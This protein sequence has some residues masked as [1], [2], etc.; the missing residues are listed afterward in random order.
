MTQ[1]P[2]HQVPH[3]TDRE[4]QKKDGNG[5]EEAGHDSFIAMARTPAAISMSEAITEPRKK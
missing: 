2:D 1:S 5:R 4:T 3:D